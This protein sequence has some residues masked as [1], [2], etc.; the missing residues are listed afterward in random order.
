MVNAEPSLVPGAVHLRVTRAV[1][2]GSWGG[3]SERAEGSLSRDEK[4]ITGGR[5]KQMSG[6]QGLDQDRVDYKE[7]KQSFGGRWNSCICQ[8]SE[9]HTKKCEFYC[10]VKKSGIL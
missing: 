9:L 2:G 7:T 4:A 10:M 5:G 1:W 6:C 3:L 8:N